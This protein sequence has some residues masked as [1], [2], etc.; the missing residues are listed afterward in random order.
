MG[1][2]ETQGQVDREAGQA[3]AAAAAAARTC[4]KLPTTVMIGLATLRLP[5]PLPGMLL[6]LALVVELALVVVLAASCRRR[7][8]YAVSEER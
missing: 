8:V 5:P 3:A 1:E 6:A 4:G 2:A 7:T